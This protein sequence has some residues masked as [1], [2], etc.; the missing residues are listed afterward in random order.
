VTDDAG[1]I[2]WRGMTRAELDAAYNN[3]A[4]VADNAAQLAAWERRSALLRSRK[5]ALLDRRYGPR[6]RNRLDIFTCG[7]ANAPLLVFIHGGYWQRNSKEIFSCMAEGPLAHGCDVALPGYTLAPGA[8]VGMILAEIRAAI[9]WL[10]RE[11]PAL[12]VATSRLIVSGWSAGGHLAALAMP[13]PEVDAGLS[14]SGIFDLEPIR[15]GALNDKLGLTAADMHTL[16]PLHQLPLRA[17]PF[18]ITYGTAELPELQR[19]SRDFFRTWQSAG[20]PGSLLPLQNCNHFTI[21]HELVAS[22]GHLAAAVRGLA[23]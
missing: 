7:V 19:Q 10:R 14:I 21:L 15:L 11:G 1:R 3:S 4:H 12:G 18:V 16:S 22:E 2:V 20:L 23:G 17:G 8:S 9:L 6:D 5:P 13:W